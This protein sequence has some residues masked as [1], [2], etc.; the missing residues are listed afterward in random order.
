VVP[1]IACASGPTVQTCDTDTTP[2]SWKVTCPGE[3]GGPTA[4]IPANPCGDMPVDLIG[5]AAGEPSYIC[6]GA[7][8]APRWTIA[9]HGTIGVPNADAG[10]NGP[11][12]GPDSGTA[13]D[14]LPVETIGCASGD[15]VYTCVVDSGVPR[16]N[17]GCP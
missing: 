11:A 16:W 7:G 2:P 9:C 8:T 13:C 17:I 1:T 4:S 6:D 14:G 12:V 15:P 10:S 5:C 3:T